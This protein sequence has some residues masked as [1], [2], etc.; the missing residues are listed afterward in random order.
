MHVMEPAGAPESQD[1]APKAREAHEAHEAGE[2]GEAGE[3]QPVRDPAEPS[4][5]PRLAADLVR[6]VRPLHSAKAL[7]LVPIAFIDVAAPWTLTAV[8]RVAWATLAFILAAAAVY[9]GNDI[10]DRRRDRHHPVK[11]HRPIAAGR[12]PVWGGYVYCG[13]LLALLA[14]VLVVAAQPFWPV[15]AYLVLNLAYSRFLKHIPLIDLGTLALGFVLRVLQG[16][17]ALGVR[18]EG[19][20]LV[21]VFSL[22]LVLL[23]GK[24]RQELLDSGAVHRPALHGYSIELANWLLQITSVFALVAGLMYIGNAAPFGPHYG[25]P[26]MVLSTPFALFTLFRYLQIQLMGRDGGDPVRLLL[27]DRVIVIT[28]VLWAA[29]LGVTMLLARYP[30]LA[31]VLS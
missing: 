13:V 15:P 31:A 3:A 21:A 20:L 23:I 19:W 28:S 29:A 6:L 16:Y 1:S 12:V 10:V 9:V 24:R 7:L 5:R 8:G 11:R 4:V 27:R 14:A 25:Q 17:L 22:S 26:A 2:V 30:A 18:V